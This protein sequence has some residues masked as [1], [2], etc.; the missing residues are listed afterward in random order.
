MESKA[1]MTSPTGNR[2]SKL[3]PA[4]FKLWIHEHP[5]GFCSLQRVACGGF[6]LV[7]ILVSITI[8]ATALVFIL[9]ACVRGAYMVTQTKYRL[10]AYAFASAKMADLELAFR[11]GVVPKAAGEF[12]VGQDQFQWHVDTEPASEN[13]QL[14]QVTLIVGWHQGRYAYESRVATLR[15]MSLPAS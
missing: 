12:R 5:S 11:Q 10:S 13:A 4:G 14:E 3:Q 15:R 2:N 6:T 7:E 1:R 9:Q 8:L